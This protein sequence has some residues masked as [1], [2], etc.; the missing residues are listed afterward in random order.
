MKMTAENPCP[1][2][3][4]IPLLLLGGGVRDRVVGGWRNLISDDSP[5]LLLQNSCPLHLVPHP[6]FFIQLL[7][8]SNQ[9]KSRRFAVFVPAQHYQT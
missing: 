7:R 6:S 1:P 5:V 3:S 9:K 4:P 2:S 8:H